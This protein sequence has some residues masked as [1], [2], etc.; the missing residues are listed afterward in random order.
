[1]IFLGTGGSES[2]PNPYCQCPVCSHART[3]EDPRDIRHRCA[4]M[5][6]DEN[7]VDFGPDVIYA[8][9]HFNRPLY[10]LRNVF[11]THSHADHW[12]PT[13]LENM[14]M[15]LTEPPH[16]RVYVSDMFLSGWKQ[17]LE[18]NASISESFRKKYLTKMA[19]YYE[20]IP[21]QPFHT[22]PIDAM[23]VTPLPTTHPGHFTGETALNYYFE[24]YGKTLLYAADTGTYPEEN[25]EFLADK[26]ADT[27][28]LEGTFGLNEPR[29]R[30]RHL[31][32]ETAADLILQL[33]KRG[34]IN[35]D[36][37]VWITH[38]SH[39]GGLTHKEYDRRMHELV[40]P[41]V[42]AAWDGLVI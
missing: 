30:G 7:A 25:F 36:T 11:M 2:I 41:Q 22:Y 40:G 28:I 9:I 23:H 38:I 35:D 5:I 20:F 10:C 42:N 21:L 37:P 31:N 17:Y 32:C 1:M 26:T 6:D 24:R 8:C 39:K 16:I 14:V 4:F 3:S 34:T 18:V 27:V 13:T 29:S 12:M 19:P 15:T 33:K